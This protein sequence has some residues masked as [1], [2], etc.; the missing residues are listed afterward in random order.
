VQ[1]NSSQKNEAKGYGWEFARIRMLELDAFRGSWGK[2]SADLDRWLL[3]NR[4][5]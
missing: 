5:L 3:Q 2:A 4:I 1:G